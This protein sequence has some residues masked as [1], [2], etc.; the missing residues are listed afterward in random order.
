MAAVIQHYDRAGNPMTVDEW[1]EA[2]KVKEGIDPRRVA[3]TTLPDGK[4]VSTVWL[5]LDHNFSGDGPPVIFES[6]VF[7]FRKSQGLGED[8]DQERYSTEEEARMGHDALVAKWMK[9]AVE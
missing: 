5:G 9:E 6:M 4:W 2:I 3:E 7:A 1:I 8:L